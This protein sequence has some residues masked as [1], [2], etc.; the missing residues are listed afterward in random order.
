MGGN[1]D[2]I[3]EVIALFLMKDIVRYVYPVLRQE[4][5]DVTFPLSEEDQ[6]LYKD[7]M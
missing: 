7:L 3:S 2:L 1:Y 6:Q 4:S 5:A